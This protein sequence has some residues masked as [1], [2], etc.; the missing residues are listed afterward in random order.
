MADDNLKQRSKKES[1]QVWFFPSNCQLYTNSEHGINSKKVRD[2]EGRGSL[3]AVDTEMVLKS[4]NLMMGRQWSQCRVSSGI[5]FG[6]QIKVK[7][8]TH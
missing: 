1:F 3:L 4:A 2:M 8:E 5:V 6:P 7:T